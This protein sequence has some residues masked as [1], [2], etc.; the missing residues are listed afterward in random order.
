MLQSIQ[1]LDNRTCVSCA[2]SVC[3]WRTRT[4]FNVLCFIIRAVASL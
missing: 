1:V 3:F 4:Y 2:Y